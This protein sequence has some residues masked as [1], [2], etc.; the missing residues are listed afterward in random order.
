M[1]AGRPPAAEREAR[2]STRRED[3]LDAAAAA[4]DAHG[5][6]VTMTAMAAEAGVTKPVLYRYFGDRAGL[7][8]ALAA[9]FAAGLL[10]RLRPAL[11]GGVT[12]RHAVEASVA[13]Y[14]SYVESHRALYRFLVR[15]LPTSGPAG[16]GLVRGFVHRV[17]AEI[18]DALG[19]GLRA[20][21]V[22][23]A[24][25]ELVAFAVT[26]TV[27]LA[28]EVWLERGTI[29]RREAVAQLSEL[30]WRGLTAIG[31]VAD[32]DTTGPARRGDPKKKGSR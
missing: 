30:L 3:L 14:L 19:P 29:P 17:A 1:H 13:A 27:Q 7:Y 32:A 15:R 8:E 24:N 5:D 16:Q 25:V 10:D 31:G 12:G 21:G 4:V 28:G 18:S 9:R 2:R 20:A 26:G 23:A 11:D 22:P 6:R